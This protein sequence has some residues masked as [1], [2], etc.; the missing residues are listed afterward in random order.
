MTSITKRRREVFVNNA[1]SF[2]VNM[3]NFIVEP[4]TMCR[5]DQRAATELR[6]NE[7]LH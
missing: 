3:I 5:P 2:L 7:R 4:L 1:Q 6:N